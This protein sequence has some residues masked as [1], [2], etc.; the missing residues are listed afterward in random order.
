[1]V[2]CRCTSQVIPFSLPLLATQ[3]AS[4]R[5]TPKRF[6][7]HLPTCTET[8]CGRSPRVSPTN[9][10]I[11]WTWTFRQW[12]T[13]SPAF[14]SSLAPSRVASALIGS[15]SADS[16]D[17]SQCPDHDATCYAVHRPVGRSPTGDV[18]EEGEELGVRRSGACLLGRSLRRRAGDGRRQL[19]QWTARVACTTRPRGLRDC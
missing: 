11:H 19:L 13:G 8:P 10:P 2:Q 6:S 16:Y 3:R 4:R 12:K 14:A 1:M 18:G 17:L 9:H 5:V 15:S 7:R